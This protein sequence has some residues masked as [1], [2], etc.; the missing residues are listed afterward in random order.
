MNGV[1]IN[2]MNATF[3]TRV[4]KVCFQNEAN[5]S[6]SATI[7]LIIWLVHVH[8][9]PPVWGR[10]ARVTDTEEVCVELLVDGDT[11]LGKDMHVL[12]PISAGMMAKGIREKDRVVIRKSVMC[13]PNYQL[14]CGT[15]PYYLNKP[16]T[17][18]C[19]MTSYKC[20][21]N[22]TCCREV[23]STTPVLRSLCSNQS[24]VRPWLRPLCV[25]SH[26]THNETIFVTRTCMKFCYV[27]TL[28]EHKCERGGGNNTRTDAYHVPSRTI[29]L[30][31]TTT[32]SILRA[33]L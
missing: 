28:G 21:S 33:S 25:F 30:E 9:Q 11:N 18:I 23:L 22:G 31:K 29:W 24:C 27:S 15:D 4:S 26:A 5:T 2:K 20:S 17:S 12:K 14:N 8:I 13:K 19:P 10:E 16:T 3:W 6:N 32:S 7:H 1:R